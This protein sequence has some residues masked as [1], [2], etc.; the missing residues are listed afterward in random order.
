MKDLSALY[1]VEFEKEQ[2]G[3]I[4]DIQGYSINDGPGI[5][6]TVFFKGCP[7]TCWWCSNPESQEQSRQLLF[8]D[9]L[10]IKC[11]QCV[12]V[13]P[14]GA[15]TVNTADGTIKLDRSLCNA[16]GLCVE[17]CPSEARV[18]SGRL[19]TVDEVLEVV[20]KDALFYRNSGGGVTASGGEPTSQ[21]QF[22]LALFRKCQESN[23]HTVLDT[24]GYVRWE[25]LKEILEYTEL[26]FFDIK[27]MVSAKHKEYTG[28]DN[29]L[30]LENAKK[31]VA[32]GKPIRI[33]IPLIPGFN[34]SAENI[35][36]TA[37]FVTKLGISEIDLLPYHQFGRNKYARLGLIY[38]LNNLESYQQEQ[39]DKIKNEYESSGIQVTIA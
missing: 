19:V 24:C 12:L 15:T 14:T 9:S 4:F 13:C 8:L 1:N 36:R 28:V 37:H 35:S 21:P 5:R 34:D 32:L 22:L 3:W 27:H 30:I 29:K 2:T 10:C 25:I 26:V 6:T 31:I 16:C 20:K 39:I 18:M 33:R 11:H 17:V 7:L 38:K 23:I